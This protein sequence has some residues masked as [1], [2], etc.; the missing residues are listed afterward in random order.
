MQE[1]ILYMVMGL[2]YTRK[3][4]VVDTPAASAADE[5]Y[6]YV[7][8]PYFNFCSYQSRK[9][10]F[11]EFVQRMSGVKN[12]RLVVSEAWFPT[13]L[14]NKDSQL[15]SNLPG[16]FS[17]FRF[18][19]KDSFWVKENLINLAVERLPY[20][21][22][23]IAWIDADVTFLNTKWVDDALEKFNQGADV[24]QLFQS[25]I[26]L[27]PD[28]ETT[29]TDQGF[30]YMC[31][32]S[33]RP[34]TKTY[35]YG[36]WHPG[37]AWAMNRKTFTA[38]NGLIDWGILGSGDHHMALSF[39][40][41]VELSHPGGLT[42]SYKKKLLD[43]QNMCK[44]ANLTLA[45]VNG[46]LIHHYHG[47]LENRKYRERWDILVK[48]LYDPSEDVQKNKFGVLEF[49]TKGKRLEDDIFQYFVERREDE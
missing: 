24:L 44:E 23:Y 41:K 13:T 20:T 47:K 3:K 46:T 35:K 34:Y 6:L 4:A 12:I 32:K 30:V 40:G 11:V 14:V 7:I 37:Y 29:K 1:K 45:F 16:V 21:W 22:K 17:H 5:E 28:G 33:G 39:I 36:F 19:M 25:A 15:P 18:D 2:G 49:T 9:Q 8:L 42:A 26:Q 27:G 38:L 10:L 48:G 31:Q 43:F